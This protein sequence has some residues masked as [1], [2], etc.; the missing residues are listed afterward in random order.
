[1]TDRQQMEIRYE[2]EGQD[3]EANYA[4]RTQH[5]HAYTRTHTTNRG[6]QRSKQTQSHTTQHSTTTAA[7]QF[8]VRFLLVAFIIQFEF[9]RLELHMINLEILLPISFNGLFFGEA[10]TTV[11]Q[12]REDGGGDIVI[13]H[14][15][16]RAARN[17]NKTNNNK[18][19][20]VRKEH[21]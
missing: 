4:L 2:D 5:T 12:R 16:L 8:R 3:M 11:F 1:M 7:H 14:L 20:S 15:H 17:A 10:H 13:V 19:T 9:Q 18:Q 6:N 21:G